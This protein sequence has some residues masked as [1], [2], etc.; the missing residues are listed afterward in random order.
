MTTDT[1]F[2][3]PSCL[4]S[5]LAK[6][7]NMNIRSSKLRFC[8]TFV[9]F[10]GLPREKAGRTEYLFGKEAFRCEPSVNFEQELA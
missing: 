5:V 8:V 10:A 1:Y 4:S 9:T 3:S 7:G 6:R 2:D